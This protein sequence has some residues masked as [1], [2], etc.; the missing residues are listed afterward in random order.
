[1]EDDVRILKIVYK[2]ENLMNN[3]GLLE[4]AIGA[5]IAAVV[6]AIIHCCSVDLP[7][8]FDGLAGACSPDM[9]R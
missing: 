2:T 8:L 9:I 6:I 7:A 5:C 4:I 3:I 1:M